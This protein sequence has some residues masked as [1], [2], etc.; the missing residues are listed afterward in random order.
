ML[1]VISWLTAA[2]LLPVAV[3]TTA[4]PAQAAGS[5][6]ITVIAQ[7]AGNAPISGM[8]VA[9]YYGGSSVNPPPAGAY[10]LYETANTDANGWATF[11]GKPDGYYK[12]RYVGT[13]TYR[14]L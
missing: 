11:S 13:S 7:G 1:R 14:T 6:L 8:Q 4:A 12:V 3:V 10:T 5:H 2:L 9:L